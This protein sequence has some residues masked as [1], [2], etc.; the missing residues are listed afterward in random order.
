MIHNT[1][2]LSYGVLVE[3]VI[4]PVEEVILLLR[5]Y[6]HPQSQLGMGIRGLG[7]GLDKN[8]FQNFN[9]NCTHS[10][11]ANRIECVCDTIKAVSLISVSDC[12]CL[13]LLRM[14][15]GDYC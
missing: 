4:P 5:F 15:L 14:A 6:C 3:E 13:T 2:H 9:L 11:T 8:C 12:H 1:I 7:L 10:V